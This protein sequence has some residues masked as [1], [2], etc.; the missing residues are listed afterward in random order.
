M[1]THPGVRGISFV[2]ECV[3]RLPLRKHL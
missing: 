2:S 1:D 3:Q